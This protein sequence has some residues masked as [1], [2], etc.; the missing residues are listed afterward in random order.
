MTDISPDEE[1]RR[2]DAVAEAWEQ[3][4]RVPFGA[5]DKWHR[6]GDAFQ[7]AYGEWLAGRTRD[8]AIAALYRA[9]AARR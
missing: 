2:Y 8:Q 4:R 1:I 3:S 6:L 9:R 7:R 5:W